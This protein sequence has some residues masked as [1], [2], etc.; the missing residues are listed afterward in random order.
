MFNSFYG[1]FSIMESKNLQKSSVIQNNSV[2]LSSVSLWE[3][4]NQ[5]ITLLWKRKLSMKRGKWS[6]TFSF[7]GLPWQPWAVPLWTYTSPWICWE[8]RNIWS[9]TQRFLYWIYGRFFLHGL[10]SRLPMA[11]LW[12]PIEMFKSIWGFYLPTQNLLSD[13]EVTI[14]KYKWLII[15]V[16]AFVLG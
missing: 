13:A 3:L 2:T 12:C 15:N 6:R 9:E 1:I 8:G 7:F 16:N 10:H 4:N 5:E 11:F 14:C